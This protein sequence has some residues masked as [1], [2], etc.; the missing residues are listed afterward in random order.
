[1]YM[2]LELV[3]LDKT[4]KHSLQSVWCL[5]LSSPLSSNISSLSYRECDVT[6]HIQSSSY[7]SHPSFFHIGTLLVEGQEA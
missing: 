1:M 5:V 4:T 3:Q 2:F 6:L 7:Y